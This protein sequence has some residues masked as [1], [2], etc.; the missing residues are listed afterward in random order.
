MAP[1]WLQERQMRKLN[2]TR[3][4]S[5]EEP[6]N[7]GYAR[8]SSTASLFSEGDLSSSR[9]PST[10]G[11]PHDGD[12]PGRLRRRSSASVL[13]ATLPK[14]M[15]NPEMLNVGRKTENTLYVSVSIFLA[16]PRGHD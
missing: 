12:V 8:R 13:G 5:V 11:L 4:L 6:H 2:T 1:S 10:V 9:R 16:P 15:R 14:F 7:G 3:K